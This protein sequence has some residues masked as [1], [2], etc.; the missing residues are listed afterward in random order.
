[1]HIVIDAEHSHQLEEQQA[2]EAYSDAR[3]IE[4][5]RVKVIADSRLQCYHCHRLFW[6][7][8]HARHEPLCQRVFMASQRSQFISMEQRLPLKDDPKLRQKIEQIG[9]MQN[10]IASG[11]FL[12]KAV[13][14]RLNDNWRMQ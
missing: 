3:S 9:G 6:P 8:S 2:L 7:E 1:M 13:K 12:S 5:G 14:A 4:N 11:M 10:A